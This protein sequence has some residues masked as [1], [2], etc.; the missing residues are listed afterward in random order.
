VMN[1]FGYF[2]HFVRNFENKIS[3]IHYLKAVLSALKSLDLAPLNLRFLP[4]TTKKQLKKPV[5]LL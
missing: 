2:S 3:L 1:D 5:G 4:Q